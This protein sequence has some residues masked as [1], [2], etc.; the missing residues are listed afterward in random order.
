MK[1]KITERGWAGHFIDSANCRFRRN[2]LV[3][4]GEKRIVVSTVGLYV[5]ENASKFEEI[6]HGRFFETMAF[7]ARKVNYPTGAFYETDVFKEVSFDSPWSYDNLGQ[8]FEANTGH[9]V[10]VNEIAEKLKAKKL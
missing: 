8:D 5:P 7:E 9:D 2:T 10:V 6:G 1:V 4:Y 3:E